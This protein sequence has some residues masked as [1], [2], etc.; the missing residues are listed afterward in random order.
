MSWL[1]S[2]DVALFRFINGTMANPF[3]DWLMPIFSSN[4]WFWPALLICAVATL[5]VGRTRGR[6]CVLMLAIVIPMGDGWISNTIKH[7]VTRPRPCLALDGVNLPM[8]ANSAI[9]SDSENGRGCSPSGSF[10]SGHTTNWF[11]ATM[12]AAMYVRRTLRFMLPLA[13]IVGFSRIYNGVHYPGDVLG[14]AILGA[15]YGAAIVFAV[16]TLWRRVG[17]AYFPAWLQRLPSLL[18]PAPGSET[19]PRPSSMPSP[20]SHWLR[21]GYVMIVAVFIGRLL[22]LA[23]DTIELSEDEAYQWLWSKH[24]ALSYFSK[25]PLIAYVQW[26]GTQL[27]GDNDFGIRFFSPVCAAIGSVV[28]LHFFTRHVNARAGFWLVVVINITP[29]LAVGSTLMTVDPLLVLF[30]TLAMTSGWRAMQSDGRAHHWLLVGLWMGLG[31]LSKYTALLQWFCWAVFFILWKP[32]RVHLKKPGPYLALAMN[33]LCA[34]PV[35]LWNLQNHW[36]SAAHV[37]NDAKLNERWRYDFSNLIDFLAGTTA[38]LHPIIFIAAVWAAI[39]FWHQKSSTPKRAALFRYFFAMGAPLFLVYLGYTFHSSVQINWIAAAV[40]P[41]FALAVLYWDER[42]RART[43][44]VRT[45]LAL[46]VGIGVFAVAIM[47]DSDPFIR[48]TNKILAQI[49]AKPLP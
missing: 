16:D 5:W 12:V 40:I 38:L 46:A 44:G 41:L 35:V 39:A 34:L 43:P 4:A 37:A 42:E 28:M 8:R 49:D 36:V 30:W 45:A 33:A 3:F 9:D 18:L 19:I 14:G 31:F 13:C 47:H 7:A 25:P 23:S 26:L 2:L 29:M 24:L 1:T 15:G 17:G 20:D 11:A 32:A 10:P 48:A 21:L 27:F 6:L 22:F